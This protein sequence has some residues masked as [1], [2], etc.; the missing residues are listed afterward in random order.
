[1]DIA[2]GSIPQEIWQAQTPT[3]AL[4]M[5]H[6]WLNDSPSLISQEEFYQH[7]NS[8]DL[9]SMVSLLSQ[10]SPAQLAQQL[11]L[12]KKTKQEEEELELANK[13]FEQMKQ[14]EEDLALA[15]KMQQE[16]DDLAFAEQ[17]QQE[18]EAQQPEVE[19]QEEAQQPEVEKQEEE[20][21][22]FTDGDYEKVSEALKEE[23]GSFHGVTK[24]SIVQRVEAISKGLGWT[25]AKAR[26]SLAEFDMDAEFTEEDVAKVEQKEKAQKMD[27]DEVD[28]RSLAEYFDRIDQGRSF[29]EE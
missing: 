5:L 15:K 2:P 29:E 19:K 16:E 20:K 7:Y 26:A 28:A 1:L 4:F 13:L 21:F 11:A 22:V 12:A 17:L 18:E 14:E 6:E 24:A 27:Q 10:S 3:H 23:F 9:N 25:N 8:I